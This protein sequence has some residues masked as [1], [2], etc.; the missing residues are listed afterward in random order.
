MKT[1][2]KR[3]GATAVLRKAGV[4]K[5]A[6][7]SYLIKVPGGFQVKT[8]AGEAAE[9]P[10]LGKEKKP[11]KFTKEIIKPKRMSISAVAREHIKA[12]KSNEEVFT[13]L[14]KLFNLDDTKKHYPSWYRSQLKRAEKGA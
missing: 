5:E 12:G 10:K 8:P 1:Y 7:D 3:D 4:P 9:A 13:I 6:Y 2:L 14:K 11:A